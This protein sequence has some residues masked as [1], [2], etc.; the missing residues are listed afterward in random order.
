MRIRLLLAIL[1]AVAFPSTASAAEPLRVLFVGNSLTAANDLP[2]VVSSLGGHGRPEVVTRTVAFGGF[3]LE[4]HWNQGDAR[5]ALADGQWD[6][7][8]LQQGPSALPESQA[9]LKEWAQRWADEIR[10]HGAQPALLTVW[11]ESYRRA[12]AFGDV[13]HS[14][15]AAAG[16]TGALLLPAGLAW[17]EAWRR[18]PRLPLYG[19]DG[20]HPSWLGTYLAAMVA[21]ARLTGTSALALPV[22]AGTTPKRA[23][24]LRQSARDAL[25]NS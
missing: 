12:Y 18:D 24:L 13:I 2:A 10:V 19:P 9:N 15:A 20:F 8:V 11:P 14:Y 4:D 17:R 25:R 23:R 7:V 6:V 5:A 21:Y 3:A 16:V 1:V 22:P